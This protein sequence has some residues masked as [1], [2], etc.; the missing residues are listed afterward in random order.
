ME[1]QGVL[2]GFAVQAHLS[3]DFLSPGPRVVLPEWEGG[4]GTCSQREIYVLLSG[5]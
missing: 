3:A 2:V 5:R 1:G 4:G